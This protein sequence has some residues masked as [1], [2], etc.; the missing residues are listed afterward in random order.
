MNT[1]MSLSVSIMTLFVFHLNLSIAV[2]FRTIDGSNNHQ[3]SSNQG[4][5]GTPLVRIRDVIASPLPGFD[6]G[7]LAPDYEDGIDPLRGITDS[8]NPPGAAIL[9]RC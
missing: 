8:N 5:A 6:R 4:R 3:T 2:E 9:I 7:S 1:Q